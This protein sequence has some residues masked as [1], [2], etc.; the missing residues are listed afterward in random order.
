MH[1][2]KQSLW[3]AHTWVLHQ[4]NDPAH[5]ALSIHQFLAERNIATLEHPPYFPD[6]AFFYFCY[7]FLFL[8]IKSVLKGTHCSDINSIKMAVMMELKK[9]PENSFQECF[10]LWKRKMHKHFQVKR[11]YFEG[12]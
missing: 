1:N 12:I 11:D 2:K 4:D 10:E 9:I 7:F 8:K 3:E 5:T 6:L